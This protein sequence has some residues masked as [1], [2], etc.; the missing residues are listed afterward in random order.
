MGLNLAPRGSL[1]AFLPPFFG[2]IQKL[3]MEI[4]VLKSRLFEWTI[5]FAVV[6]IYATVRNYLYFFGIYKYDGLTSIE[7]FDVPNG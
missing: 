1:C 7:Q 6:Y 4:S 2:K 5:N 3:Q